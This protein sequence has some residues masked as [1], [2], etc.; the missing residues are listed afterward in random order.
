M[1]SL[2]SSKLEEQVS[3]EFNPREINHVLEQGWFCFPNTVKTL[4]L[5]KQLLKLCMLVSTLK[6]RQ[7]PSYGVQGINSQSSNNAL[8]LR[9]T[10]QNAY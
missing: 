9:E 8:C 4:L 2:F 7:S 1:H 10:S 3:S 5:L 6:Q